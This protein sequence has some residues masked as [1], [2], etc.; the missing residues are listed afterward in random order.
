MIK[1]GIRRERGQRKK[2]PGQVTIEFTFTMIL[3]VLLILGIVKIFMWAGTDL[4]HRR[5]A[6]ETLL[7]Q[8]VDG[9][10]TAP[11]RQIRPHF[12]DSAEIKTAVNSNIFGD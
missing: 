2:F 5:Q 1:I 10:S 11:L 3:T 4:A 7:L 8:T 12:F 6:H 9:A